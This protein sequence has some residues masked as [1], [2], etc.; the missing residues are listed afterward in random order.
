MKRN[1]WMILLLAVV[2][3]LGTVGEAQGQS[4]SQWAIT[5]S[6]SSEYGSGD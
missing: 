2:V 5:A 3:L 4:F 6:A 1:W